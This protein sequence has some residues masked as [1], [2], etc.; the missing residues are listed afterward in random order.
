M[1]KTIGI[2]LILVIAIAAL[3]FA[4]HSTHLEGL[5]RSLHGGA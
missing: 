3:A 4:V 5:M 1:N 2:L